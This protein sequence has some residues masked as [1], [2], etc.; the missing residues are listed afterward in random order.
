MQPSLQ[1]NAGY[2]FFLQ[3]WL[4]LSP[5]KTP[6]KAFYYLNGVVSPSMRVSVRPWSFTVFRTFFV[7]FTA[8]GLKLGVL[9]CSQELLF[10]FVFQC[11]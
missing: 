3:C 10:Q 1:K 7:I 8:I 9:L 11:D 4:H 2:E 5:F 6:K